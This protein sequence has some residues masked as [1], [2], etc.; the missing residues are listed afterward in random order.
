MIIWMLAAGALAVLRFVLRLK[1]NN[2]LPPGTMGWPLLGEFIPFY[3]RTDGFFRKR[4]EVY[5][6]LFKTCLL[7]YPTIISTDPRDNSFI[8]QND[9]RLFVPQYPTSN[10]VLSGKSNL[11]TAR[12]DIHKIKRGGVLRVVGIPVLKRRLLSEIQNNITSSLSQWRG[13]N[14]N[15]MHEVEEMI[16]PLMI[17]HLLSLKP[18]TELDKMKQCYSILSKGF[19]SLP[20]KFPGTTFHKSLQ[21]KKEISDQIKNIIEEKKRNMSSQDSS[22]DLLSSMLQEA[23]ENEDGEFEFAT[24][25]IIDFIVIL[26]FAVTETTPNT[27]ALVMKRLSEN[28]HI[29]QELREEHEAIRRTKGNNESL[30]WDDYKSMAFTKNVI[31]EALRLGNEHINRMLIRKTIQ[32]VQMQG[33]TIPKGW[34]FMVF[35]QF[36]NLDS[37]YY[38]DPLAFNPRRW[39]DPGM[40]QTTSISFGGGPRHCPG[41][42]FAML[43]IS[44][45]LHHLVTTFQWDYIP[46][47]KKLG[48]FDSPFTSTNDCT[49]RLEDLAT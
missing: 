3:F 37:K 17:N 25:K 21:K 29:L 2:N 45:F 8:L 27:T 18:G 5:G 11:M 1:W 48:W 16:F 35:D 10:T 39:Q 26:L 31:K 23:V 43:F 40:N 34:T 15:V 47:K 36:S 20:C 13:R 38:T 7:G 32:N 9:G 6:N 28:P 44:L 42:D 41:Y 46:S 49:I 30:S 12:G 19:F 4:R 14:V 33:F 22:D 24:L